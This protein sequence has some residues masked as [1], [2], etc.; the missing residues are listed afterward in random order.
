[1]SVLAV[2]WDRLS[3]AVRSGLAVCFGWVGLS[4]IGAQGWSEHGARAAVSGGTCARKAGQDG[5]GRFS[6]LVGQRTGQHLSHCV[7]VPIP[8]QESMMSLPALSDPLPPE[9]EVAGGLNCHLDVTCWNYH[10]RPGKCH[11]SETL[12]G[13]SLYAVLDPGFQMV[14]GLTQ[15]EAVP[16]TYSNQTYSLILP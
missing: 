6:R 10:S 5:L 12:H 9:Q 1:V 11:S 14:E 16:A 2:G 13:T 15:A 3:L 7:R 4:M 8:V